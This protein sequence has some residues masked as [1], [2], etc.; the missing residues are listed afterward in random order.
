[1][2]RALSHYPSMTLP[3]D[4]LKRLVSGQKISMN[5]LGFPITEQ[6]LIR[7]YD[8]AGVFYGLGKATPY[9]GLMLER[10]MFDSLL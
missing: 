10:W 1:M 7:L 5:D 2:D 9:Q 6:D 4:L 8:D 3:L